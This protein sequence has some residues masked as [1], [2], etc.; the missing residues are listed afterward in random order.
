MFAFVNVPAFYQ[1]ENTNSERRI[2][3]QLRHPFIVSLKYAFQST[4]KLY[5]VTEYCKGGEL[6]FH[7]KRMRSFTLEMAK[8]YCAELT[9]ALEYLH[10][11]NIIYRDLK[12]ENILL[13]EEG[14]IKLADFGLSKDGISLTKTFC[15]TPEYIAP[16]M[17]LSS[18]HGYTQSVD[19]WALGIVAYEMLFGY[20]PF[21][22]ENFDRL[23]HKILKKPLAFPNSYKVSSS[24]KYFIQCLLRRKPSQR[25]GCG[26]AGAEEVKRHHFLNSIDWRALNQREV[27]P[28]FIPRRDR[29]IKDARN[30][31][32]EFTQQSTE[33]PPCEVVESEEDNSMHFAEFSFTYNP[34]EG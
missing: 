28:P 17:L 29:N 19:W 11:N 9:L 20:P 33:D 12:P 4:D 22:D 5:L 26:P 34:F 3:A 27:L 10:Y 24:A 14:H 31:D 8:F 23:S 32:K 13:D 7:L 1:I 2:L 30:F 18:I 6:F 25:L 21:V 16:E 15:G